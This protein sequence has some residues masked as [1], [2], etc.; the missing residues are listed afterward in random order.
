MIR[1]VTNI[2]KFESKKIYAM[3]SKYQY[4][5][6]FLICSWPSYQHTI[7][8]VKSLSKPNHNPD[9]FETVNNTS[10]IWHETTVYF[11]HQ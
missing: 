4:L 3:I 8:N 6:K 11:F 10:I 9:S 7:N 5:Y 1:K 2:L